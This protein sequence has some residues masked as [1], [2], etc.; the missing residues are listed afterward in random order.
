MIKSINGRTWFC[1]P[2]CGK[3]LHPVAPG[4]RGV[5]TKCRGKLPSGERCGWTGE[6]RADGFIEISDSL[7][8]EANREVERRTDQA[9]DQLLSDMQKRILYGDDSAG[10]P[11][12]IIRE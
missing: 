1:C 11:I 4:A 2:A 3:K 5:W 9:M 8:E 7:I 6:V 10:P 12:G